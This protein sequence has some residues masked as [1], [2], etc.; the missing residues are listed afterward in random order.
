MPMK[1]TAQAVWGRIKQLDPKISE[2]RKNIP[3]LSMVARGESFHCYIAENQI[4][5]SISKI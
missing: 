1:V 3:L 2:I 5:I 4:F